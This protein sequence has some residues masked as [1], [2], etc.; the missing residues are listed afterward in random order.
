[1]DMKIKNIVIQFIVF[2]SFLV[3]N[4]QT[5]NIPD[6]AFK[7]ELLTQGIDENGDGN[8]QKS[9]ALKVTVL[10]ATKQGIKD[11]EG[12]SQFTNLIEFGCYGNEIKNLDLRNLKKLQYLYAFD[13]LLETINING[14]TELKDI[15]IHNNPNLFVNIDFIQF[16]NLEELYTKNTRTPKLNLTKLKSLRIIDSSN[17]RLSDI[18][19]EGCENLVQ[20]WLES[21]QLATVDFK[22]LA[23][24]EFITL[25]YNPLKSIDIR[26]L[27]NLKKISCLDCGYLKQINTSG[28]ESLEPI[29]W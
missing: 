15:H 20:L 6:S 23:K 14:L 12:I 13:N 3:L 19:I 10:Y 27:K 5:I 22:Q 8:I 4:A 9:E 28:C 2:F 21:N 1:M 25:S 17:S 24:I 7:R 29:L 11:L 16:K 18:Q 26:Q